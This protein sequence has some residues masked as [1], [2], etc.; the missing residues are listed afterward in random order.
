MDAGVERP[1]LRQFRGNPVV[2][3]LADRG[4]YIAAV[5][6]IVRGYLAAGRSAACTPLASFEAWSRLVREPLL[7]LNQADP[8]AALEQ[9][10]DADP[11]LADL[12]A[13]MA[14]WE[15]EIG[16]NEERTALEVVQLATEQ[17]IYNSNETTAAYHAQCE[18]LGAGWEN[19]LSPPSHLLATQ[20]RG[21]EA[22]RRPTTRPTSPARA[23]WAVG[24]RRGAPSA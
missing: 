12:L 24:A 9:V 19:P 14:S 18:A 15:R 5:L 8:V 11:V 1:E 3:V 22:D 16:L 7:W 23:F 21:S 6:T 2:A 20:K 10:R 13:V 4:R 17:P